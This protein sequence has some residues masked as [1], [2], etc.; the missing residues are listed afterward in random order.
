LGL[1]G[2]TNVVVTS[3]HGSSIVDRRV[4]PAAD[5]GA[6]VAENGG[7]VFVYSTSRRPSRPCARSTTPVLFFPARANRRPCRS[8]WS[9]G[10]SARARSRFFA[11]L[12]G[13]G[14]RWPAWHGRWQ[15][16]AAEGRP[17]T[18]SPYDLRNTLVVQG[19]DFRAGWR[20][21]MPVGNIDI[22]PPWRTCCSWGLARRSTP[23]PQ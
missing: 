17:R 10:W 16:Q 12:V 14:R 6:V 20:N 8:A 21:R 19:P 18:I 13:G 3:D 23:R 9:A 7:S 11:G 1:R 4:S 22:A 15:Q 2:D 5:L